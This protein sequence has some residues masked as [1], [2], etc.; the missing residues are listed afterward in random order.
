MP[1]VKFKKFSEALLDFIEISIIGATI[2]ILV[3][4]FVGQLLE[5][6]GDSM[7]PTLVDGEQI[8]AEKVSMAVKPLERDEIVI[9]RHPEKQD[10][11][12]IKRVIGLPGDV[13]RFE[14]GIVV[15]NGEPLLE[16]YLVDAGHTF[17]SDVYNNGEDYSI[18]DGSYLLLGDNREESADSRSFG[19]IKQDLILGRALLVYH[20]IKNFR[21]IEH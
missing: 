7:H 9:F 8:I 13:F 14:D 5:V 11:L 2:F 6:S 3:Y 17:G 16:P 1:K 19:T 15:L 18:Q 20:P 21:V 12:L 4:L 10:R